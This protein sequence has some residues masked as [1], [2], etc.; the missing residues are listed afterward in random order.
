MTGVVSETADTTPALN[1]V[2]GSLIPL[3]GHWVVHELRRPGL[4][5]C[6]LRD[7]VVGAGLR[8]SAGGFPVRWELCVIDRFTGEISFLQEA[9][10]AK[11]D[12]VVVQID[13]TTRCE[14]NN[15]R[16]RPGSV[17]WCESCGLEIGA[18][19]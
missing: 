3:T 16:G 8:M 10:G 15:G 14:C 11:M 5:P 1:P 17:S 13:G 7:P 19:R 4:P 6:F 2:P 18:A 12:E 9:F